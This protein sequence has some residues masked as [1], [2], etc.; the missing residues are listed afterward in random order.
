M[1]NLHFKPAPPLSRFGEMLWY[2][3]HPPRTHQK[4]RLRPD[5]CIS[6]V[7]NREQDETR[8]YDADNVNK[9]TKLSKAPAAPDR[10]IAKI[11]ARNPDRRAE[12]HQQVPGS[13]SAETDEPVRLTG[14]LA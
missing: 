8:I 14:R 12:S 5:G 9:L 13:R 1:P 7:I 6:L 3:E 4:E 11:D 2:Y 10:D